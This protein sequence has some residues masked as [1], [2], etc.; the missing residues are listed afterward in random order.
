MQQPAPDPVEW[1][2]VAEQFVAD[3]VDLIFAFP[4]EPA[5][6]AKAVTQ[7]TD[8]PVVFALAGL[9]G[10]GLVE[11]IRQPGGNI[12]GVRFPLPENMVKRFEFLLELV[13]QAERVLIE[14]DPTYPNNPPGLE[15]LRPAALSAGITLV[16]E[17]IASV[18]EIQANLQARAALEDIGI[19]AILIMPEVLTQTPDGFAAIIAFAN[20]HSVPVGGA[21]PFTADLGALFSYS[22][23]A[24]DMGGLAAPLADKIFRGTPAGTIPVVTP[25]QYLRLNYRQ[26]QQLG[27]TVPEDLLSLATEIIR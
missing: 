20:E 19:D 9:E 23:D 22:P 2:R 24:V 17:P 3:K 5:V 16:E 4:S 1:Q 6:V 8:I 11:S 14:Y 13:P 12:T 26:A 25:E 18:S 27:L 7:G 15:E 10:S 21:L